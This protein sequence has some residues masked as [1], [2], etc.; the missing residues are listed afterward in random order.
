MATPPDSRDDPALFTARLSPTRSLGA[1]ARRIVITAVAAAGIVASV[2][3]MLVGA[4]PVAG[5]F[6]LDIAL[7]WLAFHVNMRD[8]R[9]REELVVTHVEL[10]LARF[11]PRG[12]RREWR[13]NPR[14]VRLERREDEEFGLLGLSLVS[15]GRRVAVGERLSPP[16]RAALAAGLERSLAEARRGRVH[17][18]ASL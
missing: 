16:E 12:E 2:P 3:F 4:W 11:G 13:F 6:G 9:G 5:F 17:D 1:E 14:W 18:H 15:G 10:L 8:A 7:V